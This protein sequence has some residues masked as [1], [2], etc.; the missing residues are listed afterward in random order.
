M[1]LTIFTEQLLVWLYS[2]LIYENC[3]E[4]FGRNW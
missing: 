4:E 1:M 2:V 3:K